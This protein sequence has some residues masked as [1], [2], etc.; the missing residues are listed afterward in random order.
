MRGV[1]RPWV[2]LD[3]QQ[4]THQTSLAGVNFSAGIGTF[5]SS[6]SPS[7]LVIFPVPFLWR[8][9]L[10]LCAFALRRC[11]SLDRRGAPKEGHQQRCFGGIGFPWPGLAF[12]QPLELGLW[13]RQGLERHA[14]RPWLG[15]LMQRDEGWNWWWLQWYFGKLIDCLQ[16]LSKLLLKLKLQL[17]LL[18]DL[19]LQLLLVLELLEQLVL[20]LQR[21]LGSLLEL[22]YLLAQ[23]CVV[24]WELHGLNHWQLWL[25]EEE[26]C[27]LW[28][29]RGIHVLRK[30][31]QCNHLLLKTHLVLING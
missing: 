24:F 5:R 28:I 16:L 12:E 23:V 31:L 9:F 8:S 27:L 3:T 29:E 1:G 4:G 11:G 2:R 19:K 15:N 6:C 13:L 22:Q 26:M 18:K 17:V 21:R 7:A 30:A 25:Q 20:L 14:L 10:L